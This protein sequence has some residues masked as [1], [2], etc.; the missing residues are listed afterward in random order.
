[1]N[2]IIEHQNDQSILDKLSA[3]RHLYD[4]AKRLRGIRFVLGVVVIVCLS[5]SRLIWPGVEWIETLMVL[6]TAIALIAEP[7]LE[8]LIG[9]QRTLAA[10]IQ[11][12]LDNQLYGFNWDECVCGKEP[13]DETICDYKRKETKKNLFNW[14]DKGIGDVMDEKVAILLCQ[15]ENVSYDSGLRSW[16]VSFSAGIAAI[17]MLGVLILSFVEGWDLMRILVF[18]VIPTIPIAEWFLTIFQD[19]SVDREHL[20]SLEGLMK[21]E[22][23]KAINGGVVAKKTLQKIQN[24]LFLHRKFGYL[25]PGWFYKCKRSKSEERAA[26]SVQEFLK[27][28]QPPCN[29][30]V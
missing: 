5:V 6:A 12:R 1:M 20:A 10:Q 2:S 21:E 16:Y 11:Q 25:I 7:W 22:T 30:C 19:N 29:G 24:L 3:Q 17:L 18:G 9:K 23:D 8:N 13:S 27:K 26:Y 15:R 14:Y 4:K 28:I